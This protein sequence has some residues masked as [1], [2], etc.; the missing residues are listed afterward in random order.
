MKLTDLFSQYGYFVLL[1]GSLG[2]GIP[3]MLFGGFAAHRGWLV[4]VPSVILVGAVG[5]VIAQS[6][7]FFGFRMAS[8]KILEKRADWAVSVHRVSGL[9]ERWD[10]PVVIGARFIPGLSSAALLAI[11]LSRISSKRFMVLNIIGAL[12]WAI[13][14]GLIGYLIGS[15]VQRFLGEIERYEEPIAVALL[16]AG[17]VWIAWSHMPR[18]GFIRRRST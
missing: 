5:N 16:L 8:S 10:A 15:A 18:L 1:I 9:L 6:A 14:L 11:A 4:L 17:A 2:E 13:S 3:I 7:W 12:I